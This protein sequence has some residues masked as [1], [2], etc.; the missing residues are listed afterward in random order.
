MA[1]EG[2]SSYALRTCPFLAQLAER[3]GPQ[4]AARIASDP[5]R[6]ARGP[7]PLL[8]EGEGLLTTFALFHG[9][10]GVVPLSGYEDRASGLLVRAGGCPYAAAG[11]RP[12][13]TDAKAVVISPPGAAPALSLASMSMSFGP[14]VR[15]RGGSCATGLLGLWQEGSR[16]EPPRVVSSR[17]RDRA[18]TMAP[19]ASPPVAR[20]AWARR[21]A[22]V[23]PGR[24]QQ[25]PVAR[26]PAA[27]RQ[28]SPSHAAVTQP[29]RCSVIITTHA[30]LSSP[31]LN[32]T[33]RRA[34]PCHR[35]LA[36]SFAA[37]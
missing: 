2:A 8:P 11:L 3:E 25:G 22:P 7:R 19:P 27:R 28:R 31:L 13:S 30:A 4:V 14:G 32:P 17:R 6:P 18:H 16:Q 26:P 20:H 15:V 5:T 34:S 1:C 9:P 37:T 29:W 36:T 10:E 33:P 12:A 35:A 21:A 24:V 23:Q